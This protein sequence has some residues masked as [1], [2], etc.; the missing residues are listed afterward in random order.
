MIGSSDKS[1]QRTRTARQQAGISYVG[2]ENS[3]KADQTLTVMETLVR[4][5]PLGA[6]DPMET[7]P[8]FDDSEATQQV[9]AYLPMTLLEQQ[10][11]K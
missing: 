5:D 1:I 11:A 6:V 4:N 9:A 8:A 3:L 7:A 2:A 10:F